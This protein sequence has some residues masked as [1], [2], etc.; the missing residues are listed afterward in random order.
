MIEARRGDEIDVRHILIAPQPSPEDMVKAKAALDSIADLIK[1]DSLSISEAASRFSDDEDTKMHG[2]LIANPYTGSTK[3]EMDQLGQIEQFLV[4]TIDKLKVGELSAPTLTQ[5][6]DGNQVYHIVY[7][8]S[9]TEP[10]RANLKDDY[11]RIQDEALAQKKEKII[12]AWIKKKLSSMYLRIADEY[13][14]CQF[15]NPWVN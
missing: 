1:K 5:G 7:V 8:K 9:R 6:R 11:Q 10:H 14:T 12:N 3:F 4:F 2:G 13:K 15:D